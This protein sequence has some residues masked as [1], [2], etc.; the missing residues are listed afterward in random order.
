M[1]RRL[2]T[3]L[4]LP[5]VSLALCGATKDPAGW[6][7]LNH[8]H[9]LDPY[10][11]ARLTPAQRTEDLLA[12]MTLEEKVGT[13]VH[14]SLPTPDSGIGASTKGYDLPAI[15]KMIEQ[16]KVNSFITRLILP[17]AQMAQANNEVQ[18]IAAATRLG[19][20]LTIS[21]DPRSH[22]QAVLGMSNGSV[23]F[24]QWPETLGFAALGDPATV[25]RFGALAAREYRAVGI[26]M[27]LSPQA[28]L[29]S[30]PRWGR[31]VGTFGSDPA[32]VSALTAAYIEGFQGG[33]DGV[34]PTGVATVVK[35]WVGYGAEPEG[36]DGHNIYGRTAKLDDRSFALHV[37]AF[38]GA[39]A[40]HPA[41]VMPTYAILS[42]VTLNGKPLEPVGAGFSH[43]LLT[44]LL[45]G[46]MGYKG[47]ILSDWAITNDCTDTC[48]APTADKP[49][50]PPAIGM[51]WG[52]EGL[53]KAQRFAKSA[54][55]GVDQFGGVN[56]PAPLL[57]AVQ[58]G[59]ISRAR[60][61]AA[62]RP[63]LMLKFQLGLFDHPFADP[64]EAARIVGA[65]QAQ[66]EADA[67]QRASQVLLEN[68][69][70]L[71]PLRAQGR[72]AWLLGIAPEAAKAAGFTPVE[73]PAQA[74][75]ALMRAATPHEKL[76]P[77]HF[78]GARQSEGRLDFQPGDPLLE[79]LKRVPASV[80]V[81]LAV[82]MDRPAILTNV[83][84]RAGAL[85]AV[86]GASDAA[87]LDVVTGKAVARGHLPFE[88]PSS[89][90]AVAAQ[91][92]ALPDD[93]VQPLYPRG[94]G[95]V[96]AAHP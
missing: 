29:A 20:P 58:A 92:P 94:A 79:A 82:D 88:L 7:D 37:A 55:A 35:H 60:I 5:L 49:Q 57:E 11:D 46:T 9:K 83:K 67:A 95:I 52:V 45:R 3:V 90:A 66:Q 30:E 80:P 27:A 91:D 33:P 16:G 84:D 69:N 61:D 34:T 86:F 25:K 56:D 87:L 50:L 51:P 43:Q 71:L 14:G 93:S 54:E 70:N 75:V 39:M 22:F 41:G 76:H 68:R 19:I 4:L 73:D 32:T 24:S 53:T 38:K 72:R 23:G 18:Q 47:L 36:F 2:A 12:R 13:L 59:T 28:D 1:S 89:M 26:H 10:E 78:F 65:P 63:V 62:V 74:D 81:V 40:V 21:T 15:K 8:N 85:L 42:G 17:P 96:L 64:A 31:Q 48:A 77:H 44:D 6:R